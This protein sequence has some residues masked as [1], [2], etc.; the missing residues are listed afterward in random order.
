ML[1][2]GTA[3][4]LAGLERAN[5]ARPDLIILLGARTGMFLGGRNGAIIP[6]KGCALIQV[7]CDGGE[8]GRTLPVDLGVVSDIEAFATA[9]NKKL[10]TAYQGSVDKAWVDSVLALS[11]VDSPFEK[12]SKEVSPGLLHPYHALKYL[13]SA[14]EPGSIIVLDGGEASAWAADLAWRSQPSTVMT[15]TGY[16]GFLGNGFGYSLGCAIAAPDR[17]VV[18][19]QGDGS[20]GFHLMELDTYKRFNLD[21]MTVIV[22]NS[23]WGMSYN[24]QEIVYGTETPARPISSLSPSTE[25]DVV[26]KGLQNNA[27]KISRVS[28]IQGTV[29]KLQEQPGPSCINLIVDKKPTHPV[30][31]AMV[32]LTDSPN[33]VVVPYYDNIPRA[34]YN[35]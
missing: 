2:K 8:I 24:G 33:A 1:S 35:I 20:A 22:N 16:L 4:I 12:E 7:D 32:G 15:A 34:Y 18:N 13:F 30:T 23:T 10:G 26:A 14:V 9:M 25:Y 3:G 5:I 19:I 17:K 21:V 27:A 6:Q 11:F 31:T 28:E 29:A